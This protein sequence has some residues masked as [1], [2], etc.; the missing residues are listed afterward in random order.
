[1]KPLKHPEEFFSRPHVKP[2]AVVTDEVHLRAILI[3][4]AELDS[5][6]IVLAGELPGICQKI[7]QSNAQ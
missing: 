6:R 3:L 1:M 2:R 7:L 4:D 5:S